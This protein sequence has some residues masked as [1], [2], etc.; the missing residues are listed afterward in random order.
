MGLGVSGCGSIGTSIR[1][2][3]F[4]WIWVL[5][6]RFGSIWV[7]LGG[8][9]WSLEGFVWIWVDLDRRVPVRICTEGLGYVRH[10][11]S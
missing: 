10:R 2:N 7:D 4:G 1:V 6:G 8:F 3:K 11:W 9:G 5:L